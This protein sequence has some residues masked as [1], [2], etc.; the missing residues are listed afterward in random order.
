MQH[1]RA[2]IRPERLTGSAMHFSWFAIAFWFACCLV[3]GDYA[4]RSKGRDRMTWVLTSMLF[5]PL[6]TFVVLLFLR[7]KVPVPTADGQT[8]P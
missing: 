8:T 7:R 5:S 3:V 6:L 2:M 4:H 1:A